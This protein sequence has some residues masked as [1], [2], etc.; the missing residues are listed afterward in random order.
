MTTRMI[1]ARMKAYIQPFERALAL[2]ELR[3]AAGADVDTLELLS[4]VNEFG[5]T[6][7]LDGAE[8]ASRLAYWEQVVDGSEELVTAQAMREATVNVVRNGID[9]AELRNTLPFT[10]KPPLPNRRCLRYGPHG[11]HEYRGK[12]FPQ[13]VRSLINVAGV[14]PGGLVVDTMSGSGT[15]L[16]EAILMGCRGAGLDMN[17]LS[18]FLGNTKC[19]LLSANPDKVREAYSTVRET[20]LGPDPTQVGR[21]AYFA[22]LPEADRAYL[23]AWFSDDVLD[24]LDDIAITIR[25]VEDDP[26][27]NL[28]WISLSNVLRSVSWQKE[29]DLRVRKEVRLDVDIDPKKEFLEELGRSVRAVL[30]LLYQ[31]GPL[32]HDLASVSQGDARHPLATIAAV[33]GT[34]DVVITSPPYAT[35]LPYLDTDRLSLCY[36]GLLP[37]PEHRTRDHSMIGNREVSEGLRRSYWERFER[38]GALLPERIRSLICEIRDRNAGS[39][40]GFR[41]LNLPSLL[42]KYFFDMREALIGIH[43]LLKPGAMAF[44]VVGNNHTIAGG[45]RVEIHTASLLTDI[46]QTLGFEAAESLSMEMLISRDIFKKNASSSEEILAF[47]KSRSH[48]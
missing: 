21:R 33:K 26:S 48:S 31:T 35:A 11:I 8:L 29:D 1:Q 45:E 13:L 34:A 47:R 27:R 41:R 38:E 12:F 10:V 28:M 40:A 20:L 15:T 5:V 19:Q 30:A 17:P 23:S 44:V 3:V 43:E 18:V 42:A 4:G 2:Q 36:L 32:P 16:V 14:G 46:A 37:R 24:S 6:S 7:K 39:A 22:T 25:C 9:L